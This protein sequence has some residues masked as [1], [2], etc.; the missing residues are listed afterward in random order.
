MRTYTIIH[1]DLPLTI[2]TFPNEQTIINTTPH[3]IILNPD[4][5]LYP[6]NKKITSFINKG[7]NPIR[8]HFD[9]YYTPI[10]YFNISDNVI[11]FLTSLT[12]KVDHIIISSCIAVALSNVITFNTYDY[13][14]FITYTI[15]D[16]NFDTNSYA[17][18]IS[19]NQFLSP[20]DQTE[21]D[22]L[23]D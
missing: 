8:S 21:P 7:N 15:D 4:I 3:S 5:T 19:I 22:N 12:S 20:V 11:D 2:H 14:Q 6:Q 23:E 18:G 10:Y 9:I 16:S 13:N 1:D 17:N